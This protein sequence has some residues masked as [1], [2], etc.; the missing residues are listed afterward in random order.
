VS[1]LGEQLA[2]RLLPQNNLLSIGG[3]KEVGRVR[4]AETELIDKDVSQSYMLMWQTYLFDIEWSL[5]LWYSL[6]NVPLQRGNI[7]RLAHS[8]CHN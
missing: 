2:R 8:S 4:L 7:Y 1:C 3:G 5:E 6:V